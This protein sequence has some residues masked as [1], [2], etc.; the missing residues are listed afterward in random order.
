MRKLQWVDIK[1]QEQ[2][3][4]PLFRVEYLLENKRIGNKHYKRDGTVLFYLTNHVRE[5]S[6]Q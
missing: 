6:T 3:T 5:R 1:T 4:C 2:E